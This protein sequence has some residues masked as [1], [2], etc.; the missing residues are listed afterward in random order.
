MDANYTIQSL[1]A[2]I[3]L[4]IHSKPHTIPIHLLLIEPPLLSMHCNVDRHSEFILSTVEPIAYRSVQEREQEYQRAR[5]RIMGDSGGGSGSGSGGVEDSAAVP[6]QP[7]GGRGSGSGGG[8]GGGARPAAQR[9][10][11]SAGSGGQNGLQRKA[12]LR[13]KDEELRDPDFR[14]AHGMCVSP[15]PRL[16]ALEFGPQI[17]DS[18]P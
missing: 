12:V 9:R 10:T 18:G 14:R 8:G 17:L 7:T 13:N 2:A 4:Y 5:A 3:I 15:C 1:C 11:G 6:V 16:Q